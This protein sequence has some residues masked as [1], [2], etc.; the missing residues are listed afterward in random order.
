MVSLLFRSNRI[1]KK[2]SQIS[3]WNFPQDNRILFVL[4]LIP[5]R[6]AFFEL[7]LSF[8]PILTFRS[9]D[10]ADLR[11]KPSFH[12]CFLVD[13]KLWQRNLAATILTFL[14][15]YFD[16]TRNVFHCFNS[17]LIHGY[18]HLIKAQR[19]KSTSPHYP[20]QNP[21]F[22]QKKRRFRKFVQCHCTNHTSQ[23]VEEER[24]RQTRCTKPVRPQKY[25]CSP[26]KRRD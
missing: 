12:P 1:I 18:T 9:L 5:R 13:R 19:P 3:L 25:V 7:T 21:A 8:R 16:V 11:T 4:P 10:L 15:S 22:T 24:D 26:L 6:H 17:E 2:F 14:N 20:Q 23:I